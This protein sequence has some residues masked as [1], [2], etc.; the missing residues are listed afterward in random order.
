[1]QSRKCKYHNT[2]LLCGNALTKVKL[3]AGVASSPIIYKGSIYVGLSGSTS[4]SSSSGSSSNQSGSNTGNVGTQ[5]PSGWTIKDNLVVGTPPSGRGSGQ[6]AVE[7][8]RHVF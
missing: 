2:W 3:G 8:W 6:I 5:L 1:M 4:T 7:S